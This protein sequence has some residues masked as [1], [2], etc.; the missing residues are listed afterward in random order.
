ME[1]FT[2]MLFVQVW[3]N[4]WWAVKLT[5]TACDDTT[6][7]AC[8]YFLQLLPWRRWHGWCRP[9]TAWRSGM[10]FPWRQW[11]S[12][13]HTAQATLLLRPAGAPTVSCCHQVTTAG[14]WKME[15]CCLC[16]VQQ[17]A[18]PLSDCIHIFG[19]PELSKHFLMSLWSQLAV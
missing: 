7:C 18:T 19:H 1:N 13:T 4:Q 9:E 8:V 12:L 5:V 3:Q 16:H 2:I 17:G 6:L 14:I 15:I 10:R 11:S